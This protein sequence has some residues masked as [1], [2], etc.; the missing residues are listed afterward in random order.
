MFERQTFADHAPAMRRA[1]W[2]VLLAEGKSPLVSRFNIWE[3][4]PGAYTIER[5]AK[6]W[7]DRDIVYVPGVCETN[8]G[9]GVIVVDADNAEAIG[10]A[11]ELF[12]DTP[13]KVRTRRGEHRLFARPASI[14]AK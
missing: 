14:W 5:W 1:G 13:A 11:E 8:K 10:Q 3:L 7:P 12:G 2:A 4:A 6:R 9:K